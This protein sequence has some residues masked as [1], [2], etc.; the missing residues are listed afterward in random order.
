MENEIEMVW[1]CKTW[2][3]LEME[4]KRPVIS[5]KKTWSKVKEDMRMLNI[6]EDK[7]EDRKHKW[8]AASVFLQKQFYK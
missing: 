2:M 7:A 8:N 5:P 6:T 4:G 1:S 3:E